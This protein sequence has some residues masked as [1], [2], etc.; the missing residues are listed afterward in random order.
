MSTKLV[1]AFVHSYMSEA[2][3]FR[4]PQTNTA[5]PPKNMP[6]L[7]EDNAANSR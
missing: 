6:N 7:N 5:K 3:F 4:N 1:Y 2:A